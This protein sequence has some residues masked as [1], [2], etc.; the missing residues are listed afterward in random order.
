MCASAIALSKIRRIYYAV[1]DEKFGAIEN[2]V[3][4]FKNSLC[5]RNPEIYSGFHEE[6]SKK[7]L[8]DF[9]RNKR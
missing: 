4:I 7:L 5:F 2:G 3:K 8:V 6:E 9:F 1:S